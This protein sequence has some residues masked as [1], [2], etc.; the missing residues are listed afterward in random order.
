MGSFIQIRRGIKDTFFLSD[1][2]W[3]EDSCLTIEF[4]KKLWMAVVDE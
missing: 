4:L 2:R 1:R 3:Y